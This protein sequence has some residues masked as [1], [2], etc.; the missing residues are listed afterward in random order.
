MAKW[1]FIEDFD[2][3]LELEQAINLD[4][5]ASFSPRIKD[6]QLV[7]FFAGSGHADPHILTFQTKELCQTAYNTLKLMLKSEK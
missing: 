2:L 1:I 7:I 4:F 6:A 3:K 5:V